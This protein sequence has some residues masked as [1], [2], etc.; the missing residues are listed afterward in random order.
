MAAVEIWIKKPFQGSNTERPLKRIS[1]TMSIRETGK[2]ASEFA[3]TASKSSMDSIHIHCLCHGIHT[4]QH[5]HIYGTQGSRHSHPTD[6]PLQ[7]DTYLDLSA[8]STHSWCIPQN[9]GGHFGFSLGGGCQQ[10]AKSCV[11]SGVLENR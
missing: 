8:T 1:V 9:L 2:A 5:I 4:A 6:K 7:P 11:S 10:A 3:K